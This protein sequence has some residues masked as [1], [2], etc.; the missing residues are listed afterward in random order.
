[1][2]FQGE[3]VLE[4]PLERVW[5]LFEDPYAL[6]RCIP[7][8]VDFAVIDEDNFSAT[9]KQ[10]VGPVSAT[11]GMHLSVLER[12]PSECI[13]FNAA[14][15]TVSGAVSH[16]RTEGRVELEGLTE[17]TRVLLRADATVAGV[18]GTVAEKVLQKQSEKVTEQFGESLRRE[19]QEI[20]LPGQIEA[21]KASPTRDAPS[22]ATATESVSAPAG[23]SGFPLH[24]EPAAS[25]WLAALIGSVAGFLLGSA[26]SRARHSPALRR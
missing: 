23:P 16:L 8:L 12:Q 1:V 4:S 11:F 20:G 14:G 19:L 17:G 6:S 25:A 21:P 7:G 13:S 5:S 10:A 15:K 24:L 9:V 26:L 22:V 3:V 18:L 2:R